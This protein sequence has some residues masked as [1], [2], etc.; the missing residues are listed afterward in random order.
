[1]SMEK[2]KLIRAKE[3][4]QKMANGINPFNGEPIKESSFLQEPRMIRCLFFVQE[5]LDRA[6]HGQFRIAAI[7]PS[8]FIISGEEKSTIELPPGKIGVSEFARC[9]NKVIDINKSKK[10]TGTEIN[11]QLKKMGIL[12]DQTLENGKTKTV[13]NAVSHDYEIE[14][15]ER[16]YNGRQY[17][18]VVFNDEG[19]KFLLE[20]LERIMKNS[21]HET[22]L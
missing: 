12:A 21:G 16:N 1:M 19:K 2:E 5:V 9:V 10:L 3:I 6:I 18:M 22:S 8:E 13:I 14:M 4:L 7:R 20:N 17:E 11:K 15:E